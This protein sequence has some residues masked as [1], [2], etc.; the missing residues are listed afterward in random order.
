MR[1]AFLFLI[2]LALVLAVVVWLADRPG[3]IVVDWQDWRIETTTSVAVAGLAILIVASALIY[4][5]WR[6]ILGVPRRFAERR[7]A[8]RARTVQETTARGLIALAAGDGLTALREARRLGRDGPSEP[9][10]LL[11]AAQ[12]AVAAG[13]GAAARRF[14]HQMLDRPETELAALR[15][16]AAEARRA[17]DVRRAIAL[18]ER[19]AE[20]APKLDWP[21]L[22]EIELHAAEGAHGD[23]EAALDRAARRRLLS[24]E[25]ARETKSAL[26]LAQ[27]TSAEEKGDHERAAAEAERAAKLAPGSAPALA[28]AARLLG[29][30]GKQRRAEKLIERH[31]ATVAHPDVALAYAELR[32]EEDALA[33]VQRFE[34]LRA[35]APEHPETLIAIA[36]AA[37]AARLFGEARAALHRASEVQPGPR[38]FAL[39]AALEQAEYGD[40]DA[41]LR[42]L[43]RALDAPPEAAWRCEGCGGMAAAWA[44]SCGNCGAVGRLLWSRPQITGGAP[45]GAAALAGPAGEGGPKGVPTPSTGTDAVT[46]TGGQGRG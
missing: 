4:S 29:R 6:W 7:A 18:V 10:G 3:N 43:A 25:A 28:R 8:K 2:K 36:R 1:R 13:D 22:A 15:G 33:R 23:A 32:P 39:L 24:P 5:S 9:L 17:G 21:A 19:A 20:L 12:S 11:L 35:A 34:R 27:S 31:W 16:L 30:Q 40:R 38:V 41:A 14:M 26:A 45:L 46:R 44:A 42:W 37:L